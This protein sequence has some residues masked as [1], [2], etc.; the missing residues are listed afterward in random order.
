MQKSHRYPVFLKRSG[1]TCKN[2]KALRPFFHPQLLFLLW[3]PLPLRSLQLL[4]SLRRLQS[5]AL[6][7][8]GYD[9]P[10]DDDAVGDL[11][12]EI[13]VVHVADIAGDPTNGEHAVVDLQIV[14][15]L[16]MSVLRFLL[17]TDH[18]KIQERKK[19]DDVQDHKSAVTGTNNHLTQISSLLTTRILPLYYFHPLFQ[20]MS[21]LELMKVN[22][23]RWSGR[24]QRHRRILL[25]LPRW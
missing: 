1:F 7:P 25:C 12:V 16:L 17:R 18:E 8:R 9:V 23:P 15:H 5:A 14:D 2:H 4:R 21:S 20:P 13:A 10:R 3:L 6:L 19:R 24:N 22:P 11:D